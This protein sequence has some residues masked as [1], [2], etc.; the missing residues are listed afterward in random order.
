MPIMAV[1][2]LYQMKRAKIQPNA[3]TYGYY[4]KV[5]NTVR[6]IILHPLSG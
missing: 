5:R 1:K 2:V 3:I 6:F 4:N